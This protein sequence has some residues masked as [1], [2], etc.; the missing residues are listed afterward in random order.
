MKQELGEKKTQKLR[1]LTG[2]PIRYVLVKGGWNHAKQ[3]VLE[4]GAVVYLSREGQLDAASN[5]NRIISA[6]DLAAVPE[7][8]RQAQDRIDATMALTRAP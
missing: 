2:L 5:C 7:M 4:S 8:I 6:E 1:D 3:L